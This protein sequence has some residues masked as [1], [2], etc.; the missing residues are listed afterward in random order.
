MEEKILQKVGDPII[1]SGG[2]SRATLFIT[3]NMTP[4][5]PEVHVAWGKHRLHFL[6]G[7]LQLWLFFTENILF[8]NI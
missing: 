5:Y 2:Q 6:K 7:F 3:I 8:T 1:L 4:F